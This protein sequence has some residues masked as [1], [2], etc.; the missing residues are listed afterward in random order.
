VPTTL[1]K[2]ELTGLPAP[3]RGKVRDVYDLGERLL[4]VATDRISAFDVVLSPG[5]PEKGAILTRL[6]TFW[7]RKFES[8]LPNHL[9][10]TEASRFPEPLASQR[11]LLD[12]RAVL[13]RKCRVVPFECVARGYIAGSGW[14]EYVKTGAVCGIPLPSGL[15]ESERLPYPIFTPATKAEAGHDENVSY[16]LMARAV[17]EKL[18]AHLRALTLELYGQ[19]AAHAETKGILIADTKFEFGLDDANEV[20]WIDE[21]LTPDSSRFW[22]AATYRTGISPPS[23]DKQFVRDWLE[24]TGWNKTPPAP[25]LPPDVVQGTRGRY[26]EAYRKL[27]GEEF[28][29]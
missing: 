25:E 8:V 10:E 4:L 1:E 11:A 26:V 20:V 18:A 6:S 22:D 13:A 2:T 29:G 19:A 24:R 16:E 17:G 28:Q 9:I 7:F 23:Y 3:K 27:T 5:V 14:K 12:G 15:R 21:A